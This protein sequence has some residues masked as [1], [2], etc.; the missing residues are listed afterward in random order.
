[1]QGAHLHPG[2]GAVGAQGL[3]LD[4]GECDA[5][6]AL[7]A[8]HAGTAARQRT[9]RGCRAPRAVKPAAQQR[10]SQGSFPEG[11]HVRKA[12]KKH[13]GA[14]PGTHEMA[15]RRLFDRQGAQSTVKLLERRLLANPEHCSSMT[16]YVGRLHGCLLCC[17]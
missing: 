16:F 10:S 8:A 7:A 14:V 9:H 6:V 1:V 12:P 11:M 2:V 15:D 17:C 4:G 3:F 5:P 13:A